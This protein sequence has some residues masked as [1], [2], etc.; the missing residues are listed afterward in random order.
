LFSAPGICTVNEDGDTK[1]SQEKRL[2]V[3]DRWEA[4]H[5]TSEHSISWRREAVDKKKDWCLDDWTRMAEVLGT[6]W[7]QRVF[8]TTTT[9]DFVAHGIDTPTTSCK[10]GSH[11]GILV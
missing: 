10:Q 7:R 9:Y 1:S 8:W 6:G 4:T 5:S 3:T 11:V 2:S